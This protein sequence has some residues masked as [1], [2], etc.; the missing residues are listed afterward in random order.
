MNHMAA[1][2]VTIN[3]LCLCAPVVSNEPHTR[4]N[5]MQHI[6][7]RRLNSYKNSVCVKFSGLVLPTR[8]IVNDS[9]TPYLHGRDRMSLG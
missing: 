3:T 4:P 7:R 6:S 2:G 5:H 8:P 9:N 1:G